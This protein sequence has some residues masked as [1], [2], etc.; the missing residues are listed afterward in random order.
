MVAE[1]ITDGRW[2]PNGLGKQN[3]DTT[4]HKHKQNN[5]KPTQTHTNQ[6]MFLARSL[7][8]KVWAN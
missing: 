2:S 5:T 6:R 7:G 3:N 4:K 8:K 1:E